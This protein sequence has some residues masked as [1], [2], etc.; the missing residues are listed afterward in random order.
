VTQDEL[1]DDREDVVLVHERHLDVDLRELGLAVAAEILVAEALHD[2]DVAIEARDHEQ[3]LEELRALGER[4][5][6]A[7]V[8]ARGH[9]EV[10]RAAG[11]VLHEDRRLDLDEAVV[12]EV[13]AR[14]VV[15]ARARHHVALQA[16]ASEVEVAVLEA[17]LLARVDVVLDR[18][19]GRLG[20]VEDD[21]LGRDDLDRAGRH[22]RVPHRATVADLAAHA[23]HPLAARLV[24]DG[25]GLRRELRIEHHLR[26]ALAVAEVDEDAAAVIAPRVDPAEEHDLAIDVGVSEQ[27]AVVSPLELVDEARHDRFLRVLVL[28]PELGSGLDARASRGGH[29]SRTPRGREA[30]DG[31]GARGRAD[32]RTD[33]SS[34]RM[35]RCNVERVVPQ[36][37]RPN[38]DA[39]RQ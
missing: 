11:R 4:V 5:E 24:A 25:E 7:G 8:Q 1:L 2:L 3:L 32:A 39:K 18:E 17:L 14:V 26:D 38:R 6:E 22:L 15:D 19:D 9:E 30:D 20:L 29:P 13:V 23:E 35:L 21:R 31:C 28:R 10:A 27:A 37:D 16:R 34:A 33:A 36:Q 12:R